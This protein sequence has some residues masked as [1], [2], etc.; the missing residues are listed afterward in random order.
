M[1][2]KERIKK[3]EELLD[4]AQM[5]RNGIPQY[6]IWRIEEALQNKEPTSE[7][8]K[9]FQSQLEKQDKKAREFFGIELGPTPTSEE[10][11]FYCTEY[12]H[13]RQETKCEKQCEDCTSTSEPKASEKWY[14]IDC[15]EN[16]KHTGSC[17]KK[18]T[19]P[20]A[21]TEADIEKDVVL[22]WEYM[23]DKSLEGTSIRELWQQ[24]KQQLEKK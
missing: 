18:P 8:E 11:S 6:I 16:H 3:L 5:H 19:S 15:D 20:Q 12:L 1:T 13:G 7:E 23:R 9:S 2:D 4:L 17:Y 14:E 22:F 21:Y 24:Y 10:E